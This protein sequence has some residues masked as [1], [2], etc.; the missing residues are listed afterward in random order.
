MKFRKSRIARIG[1]ENDLIFLQ[2]YALAKGALVEL[3][4]WKGGTPVHSTLRYE[5]SVYAK[6]FREGSFIHWKSLIYDHR[7]NVNVC[8]NELSIL[9]P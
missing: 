2:S 4:K 1:E 7:Y 8:S 9:S 3:V 5:K 6:V